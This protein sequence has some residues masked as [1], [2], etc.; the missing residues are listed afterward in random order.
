MTEAPIQFIDLGAQRERLGAALDEAILAVVHHG[1]YIMGPEVRQLEAELASYCGVAHVISC[2]SGTDALLLPLMAWGVG[3]GDAVLVPTFTF[4]ATAEAVALLGAT[5]VF[6]DVEAET[7]NLDPTGLRAA[8]DAARAAGLRPVGI[9]AVDLFGH[10]APYE[11][12]EAFAAD[13]DLWVMADA[14]QSFGSTLRGRRAGQFGQVTATSFFPAKPLGCYGDGGA[15]F[16]DD[17]ELAALM[18]SL[19]VHGKGADKYD[20]V[21]V[22]LNAR[23][24]TIQAAVLLQKLSIFE[25]ELASRQRVSE[26]YA[27]GL[28]GIVEVPA[29]AEGATSAWAQYTVKVDKR[30]ALATSLAAVGI[31]TNIYYP[32]PLHQQTAYLGFPRAHEVLKTAES[33]SRHVLSLPMSP[34][35]SNQD[36]DRVVGAITTISDL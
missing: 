21:R 6:V 36:L 32:V 35:L 26:R 3:P 23:L 31:P 20:N 34:Y 9:I 4:A 7:F 10:P 5:P 27:T 33:L 25:D 24:D 17:A 11:E 30:D 29:L 1:A 2:S 16:T 19:R 28:Q 18:H 22:G 13:R 8:F 12:I 14:A 15:V